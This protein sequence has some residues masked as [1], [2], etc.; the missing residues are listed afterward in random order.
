MKTIRKIVS[1][2]DFIE[3]WVLI[4]LTLIM[5]I[6]I[7]AQVFTRYV[8]G[9][10]LYWSEEL[11]KFIFVWI[12][13]LGVSAGMK[14]KEHI[15]V[16]LVHD[17]LTKKGLVKAQETLELL[18]NLCWFITS[19]IVTYY[20]IGIVGMQMDTAVYGASTGIP[21]WIPYLCVPVSGFIICLRLIGEMYKNVCDLF[22]KRKEGVN[23]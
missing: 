23:G 14:E 5:V 10:A 16:R 3:K 13:W 6:V 21:M 20:G 12:S 7:A 9:D 22:V 15:Q 17:A 19:V 18:L 8:L 11:G 1:G 2:Y 4:V